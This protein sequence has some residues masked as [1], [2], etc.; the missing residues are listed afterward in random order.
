MQMYLML[1]AL[2]DGGVWAGIPKELSIKLIAHT[3]L[4]RNG[5][6]VLATH[7][8]ALSI[9]NHRFTLYLLCT[10]GSARMVLENGKHP[11]EVG[12]ICKPLVTP[13]AHVA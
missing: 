4:V 5:R 2:A 8:L 13:A 7:G 6:I 1:D 9:D 12:H 10:Q 11:A 3:M